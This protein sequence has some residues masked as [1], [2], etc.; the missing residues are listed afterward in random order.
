MVAPGAGPLPGGPL[1][2]GQ[3]AVLSSGSGTSPSLHPE[4]RCFLL[5]RALRSE[6]TGAPDPAFLCLEHGKRMGSMLGAGW[7]VDRGCVGVWLL[8][9]CLSSSEQDGMSFEDVAIPFSRRSVVSLRGS[10]LPVL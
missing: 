1:G 3:T 7:R 4:L 2:R 5:L 8:W 10:G 6:E 9:F